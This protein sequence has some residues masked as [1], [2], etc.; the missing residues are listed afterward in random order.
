MGHKSRKGS[1]D[2]VNDSD[3]ALNDSNDQSANQTPNGISPVSPGDTMSPLAMTPSRSH[4]SLKQELPDVDPSTDYIEFGNYRHSHSRSSASIANSVFSDQ[5][6]HKVSGGPISPSSP[7]FS[8]EHSSGQSPY[9]P[10]AQQRLPPLN[11][12]ASFRPRR[13]TFPAL[14]TEQGG[15]D[16]PP[17]TAMHLGLDTS[18]VE[19]AEDQSA[20][21][22]PNLSGNLVLK[23][24]HSTPDIKMASTASMQPPPPK[25]NPSPIS[26]AGSPTQDDARRALEVVWTFFQNQPNGLVVDPQEYMTIGKLM[27][28]LKLTQSA[29]AGAGTPLP[30]GLHPIEEHVG[31]GLGSQ[32]PRVSKKRS[33]HSL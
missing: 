1:L 5:S 25:Q 11:V 27:E 22:N 12:N 29:A 9:T 6:G 15:L 7:Y 31:L 26:P 20:Q 17:K 33:I 32:S 24:N 4:E 21:I 23:R 18:V 14:G 16:E 19:M 2:V 28:K 10:S 8:S 13:Q 30:G 3:S